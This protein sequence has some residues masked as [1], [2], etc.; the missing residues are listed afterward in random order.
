MNMENGLNVVNREVVEEYSASIFKAFNYLF[1]IYSF[2]YI[3]PAFS[4]K[5]T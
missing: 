1:I 5:K 2:I 3:S 4:R